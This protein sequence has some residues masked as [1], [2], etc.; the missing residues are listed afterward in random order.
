MPNAHD[1]ALSPKASLAYTLNDDW[2]FRLSAGRGVRF[3]TVPELFQG[4]SSAGTIV[5][6]DPNLKPERS[7]SVDFTVERWTSWGKLRATLFQD[8][9][10]DSIFSQT[11]IT[12]TPNVTNVQNVDRVRTRGIET[13]FNIALPSLESV[14]FD[15]S[16]AY[17]QAKILENDNYPVS[18][19]NIWPR[20]PKW[21]GNL[22]T[23]WRPTDQWL[24]SLGFVT[25]GGCSIVWR[26]T[27]SIPIRMAASRASPFWMRVWRTRQQT[28]S[29]WRWAW[30]TSPTSARISLIPIRAARRSSR[31][32]GRSRARHEI[33]E[34]ITRFVRWCRAVAPG[35]RRAGFSRRTAMSHGRALGTTAA[36]DQQKRLWIVRSEPVDKN[37]HV[38]LERSDDNGKTW[39]PA[40]RVT[41]KP[42]PVSADGENRPKIAFGARDEIYVTW[43]HADLGQIHRRHPLRAIFGWRQDLVGA[44][45][46]PSRPPAHHASIRV[47]AGRSDRSCLGDLDRQA[48]SRRRA[49]GETRVRGRGGLLRV[50]GRSR[51]ELEGRLQTCRQHLRVLPDRPDA[52]F[53]RSRRGDVAS[54]VPGQRARS[55]V[56]RAEAGRRGRR[57]RTGHDGSMEDRRAVPI[58][59]RRSRLPRTAL[60]MPCGSIKSTAKGARSMDV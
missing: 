46:R 53:E 40:I 41:A 5:V 7:D 55:C 13:A 18:V 59:D 17:A 31:R 9:V 44:G 33:V 57:C 39:Q 30:T 43:T 42:E 54:C 24:T 37:A 15:G 27:T 50:L 51:R 10:R 23:V 16:L 1:S 34:F 35:S 32:A 25:R 19:G 60:V 56:R 36:F 2:T 3:P 14:S 48:R 49:S 4:T 52:R 58:T 29:S 11:N 8:D 20:I 12:V 38:V 6:N 28:T 45:G 21:R 26:T 22:Q 47:A